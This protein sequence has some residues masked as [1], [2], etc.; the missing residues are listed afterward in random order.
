MN[1]RSE[2]QEGIF[3]RLQTPFCIPHQCPCEWSPTFV[4]CTACAPFC[5]HVC[6]SL[7]SS[8]LFVPQGHFLFP[9]LHQSRKKV[10]NE[11]TNK[12]QKQANKT[13]NKM[14]STSVKDK[15]FPFR[16]P[17]K[18]RRQK[19]VAT[20]NR[21]GGRSGLWRDEEHFKQEKGDPLVREAQ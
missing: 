20:E 4:Q 1:E 18:G 15:D 16:G 19:R 8:L 6:I 9:S 13:K 10:K 12:T 21:S 17:R 11:Q 5:G 7:P 14:T 2:F 3:T